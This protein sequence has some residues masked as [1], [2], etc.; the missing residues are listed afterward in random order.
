MDQQ[1]PRIAAGDVR[2]RAEEEAV[3]LEQAAPVDRTS[4]RPRSPR[5]SA[6]ARG[7][8]GSAASAEQ[9]QAHRT[10]EIR[11]DIEQTRG[12]LSETVNAIQER[13][14]PGHIA[15]DAASKVKT[16]TMERARDVADSEPVHYVRANPIPTA[17]V[18]I[19]VAGLAWLAVAGR[20]P[21]PRPR[22]PMSRERDWRTRAYRDESRAGATLYAEDEDA[23]ERVVTRRGPFRDDLEYG[24]MD[25]ELRRDWSSPGM[26]ERLTRTWNE[27]PLVIGAA[28]LVAGAILGLSVPET[29]RENRLMGDTR[30]TMLDTV[31]ETVRDKATEVQEKATRA[32]DQVQQI[33]KNVVGLTGD[34]S[35]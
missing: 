33:A 9:Q 35:S 25:P 24:S 15:S 2:G 21:R 20:E 3:G 13:L 19:G 8:A 10:S 29:E 18:G 28:A 5:S 32:V 7:T 14:R 1:D 17:M 31:Q 23:G 11:A 12:E 22:Y 4:A 30:D 26:S 27:N 6:A 16:A 34:T